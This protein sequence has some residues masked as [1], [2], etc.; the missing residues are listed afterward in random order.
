[1][2]L[3]TAPSR[4]TAATNRYRIRRR[5]SSFVGCNKASALRAWA[6]ILGPRPGD[7]IASQIMPEIGPIQRAEFSKPAVLGPGASAESARHNAA[8]VHRSPSARTEF[9]RKI[10]KMSRRDVLAAGTAVAMA[11]I[12]GS[13]SAAG[14]QA[15]SG[16]V[17]S[18][19]HPRE[20][21][22]F[23]ILTIG[24]GTANA[25]LAARL[26]AAARRRV[27]LLEA[28]PNFTLDAYPQVLKDA[29]FIADSP[30][31]DWHYRTGDATSLGH[32]IPVPRDR[33][34]GESS[35]VNAVV[36][37]RPRP[38]D[39]VRCA[40]RGIDGWSW[41]EVSAVYKEIGNTT[42]GNDAR[43]G[44]TGPFPIRQRTAEENTQSIRALVEG[45]QALGLLRVSDFN[46]T[47]QHG[48]GPYQLNVVE[49][50]HITTGMAYLT[51]AVGA[52]SNLTIQGG[53]E[54]DRVIPAP[55]A[56]RRK[57]H[58]VQHAGSQAHAAAIRPPCCIATIVHQV[59]HNFQV[60]QLVA[61]PVR[62]YLACNAGR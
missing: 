40:K 48:A 23:D 53:A 7:G 35:A 21:R 17:R 4:R 55:P 44:R 3:T 36:A 33:V 22:H 51:A 2:R 26:S 46:G 41:D 24:G 34:V 13:K 12:T 16:D 30:A 45:S 15:Q 61:L 27:V 25:I 43:H 39:F 58:L 19:K 5:R 20:R 60:I 1:M 29:N 54:V 57:N 62:I 59:G 50:V 6:D 10:V 47:N 52:C 49:E 28:G 38:A 56:G 31:F 14:A 9:R 8:E 18:Q 42:S 32:D 11:A 37:M